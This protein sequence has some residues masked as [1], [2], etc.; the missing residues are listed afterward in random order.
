MH[1]AL[2]SAIG[3]P[4]RSTRALWMLLF[5][6]PADVSRNFMIPRSSRSSP[7]RTIAALI[8]LKLGS[9]KAKNAQHE[10]KLPGMAQVVVEH[11]PDGA[12]AV[13]LLLRHCA[14][15]AGVV[16]G[17]GLGVGT[18]Y[19]PCVLASVHDLGG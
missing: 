18:K 17:R 3:L 6:M 2:H 15:H 4:R 10:G 5:L 14:G 12:Q 8:A 1:R 11:T 16:R 9:F 7:C 19:L 13:L